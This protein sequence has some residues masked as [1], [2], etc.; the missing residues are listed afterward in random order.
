MLSSVG[1]GKVIAGDAA[2]SGID[3]MD[4]IGINLTAGIGFTTGA[5][6]GEGTNTGSGSNITTGSVI[7][8]VAG[9]TSL[10]LLSLLQSRRRHDYREMEGRIFKS[11]WQSEIIL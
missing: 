4:G 9:A 1:V 3:L 6:E 10:F 11:I 5:G 2:G 8:T 7:G